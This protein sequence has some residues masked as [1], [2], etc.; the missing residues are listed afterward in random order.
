MNF[1]KTKISCNLIKSIGYIF[2]LKL[3]FIVQPK[4]INQFLLFVFYFIKSSFSLLSLLL[5]LFW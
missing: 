2:S 1:G 5:F 3:N 4:C